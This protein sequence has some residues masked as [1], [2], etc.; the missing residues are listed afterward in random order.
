MNTLR[1]AGNNLNIDSD[2]LIAAT[3][4]E[5][6]GLLDNLT[7]SAIRGKIS[8]EVFASG[9]FEL[10]GAGI[11][12]NFVGR[13]IRNT[14]KNPFA[15]M[16]VDNPGIAES[17]ANQSIGMLDQ[18]GIDSN[19]AA[20]YVGPGMDLLKQAKKDGLLRPNVTDDEVAEH[21]QRP[22]YSA[23][24][25]YG[26]DNI[27]NPQVNGLLRKAFPEMEI[28]DTKELEVFFNPKEYG[29]N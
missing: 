19:E 28:G 22:L 23:I 29:Y 18:F 14:L 17:M 1:K 24:Q 21:I 10:G 8:P 3:P 6:R 15:K 16:L 4:E 13:K 26:K 11:S 5:M 7:N 9:M 20:S 25:G 2:V 27:N 12:P